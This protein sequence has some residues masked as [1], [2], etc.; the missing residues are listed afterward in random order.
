MQPDLYGQILFISCY[1][2]GDG[3]SFPT[4]LVTVDP[5]QPTECL[6]PGGMDKGWGAISSFTLGWALNKTR[7]IVVTLNVVLS[8]SA[9]EGSAEQT[10]P[11]SESQNRL[12]GNDYH[13]EDHHKETDI[14]KSGR[15]H[16]LHHS[17]KEW[18]KKV[19][20]MTSSCLS[21]ESEAITI[22]IESES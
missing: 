15:L 18:Q 20:R 21:D 14:L 6:Q 3:F 12:L 2:Q 16:I 17:S 5:E 4:R 7:W 8:L 13:I 1:S 9:V 22:S 11:L 10:S 19:Q